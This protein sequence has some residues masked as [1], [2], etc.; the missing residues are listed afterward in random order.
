ML[1]H[2]AA[3][4]ATLALLLA[5]PLVAS[6]AAAD[7]A[8]AAY[9]PQPTGTYRAID[10]WWVSTDVES[11]G[12]VVYR[13]TS[14][15][16]LAPIAE[17]A[18]WRAD[19]YVDF[20]VQL[21]TTYYYALGARHPGG[22][23]PRSTVTSAAPEDKGILVETDRWRETEDYS[24]PDRDIA[25]L[26][27][28]GSPTRLTFGAGDHAMPVSSRD[29]TLVAYASDEGNAAADY[30]VWVLPYG[31]GQPRR[32]T[33]DPGSSDTD[34]AISPDGRTVA[35]TRT[36]AG[37]PPSVWTVPLAGGT[38]AP[39]PNTAKCA[40]PAWS[41]TGR[42]LLAS[43]SNGRNLLATNLAGTFQYPH[44][45]DGGGSAFHPPDWA[46]DGRWISFVRTKG[47]SSWIEASYPNGGGRR[48]PLTPANQFVRTQRWL[49]DGAR[50]MFGADALNGYSYPPVGTTDIHAR[51][52]GSQV[53]NAGV[54][55]APEPVGAAPP[56]VPLRPMTSMAVGVAEVGP[57]SVTLTWE[58]P[59]D[60]GPTW[61][62]VRRGAAGAPA[63][64]T[65]EDGVA[66]YSG[67]ASTGKAP[68]LAN[69]STYSFAVFA[70]DMNGSLMAR[71]ERTARPVAA[72]TLG[73]NGSVLAVLSGGGPKFAASWGPALPTGMTY[74]VQVG[75][76]AKSGSTWGEPAYKAFYAGKARSAVVPAKAGE[77][78]HLRVRVRDGAKTT[79]W[80]APA[81]APVPYD[82]RAMTAGG[83]WSARSGGGR[84][85]GTARAAS[86]AGASLTLAADGSQYA[87]IADRCP[88]CG[89]VKIYVDG[90]LKATVDTYAR[91]AAVRQVV[92]S[93][94][95]ASIGAH[96]IK[97]VVVGT[98]K[99][100]EVRVD[101]VAVT[102]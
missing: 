57:G 72:P 55:S 71:Q 3:A 99:R 100:P 27:P 41:P 44:T 90:V 29:G 83:T 88:S 85:A 32:L 61:S 81:V 59:W 5:V 63:P 53:Y 4:A 12:Y 79:A 78:Y 96:K 43:F 2:K 58:R 20:D 48:G 70:L 19:G 14:P 35:F 82:D 28:N 45:G 65:P 94:R 39:V 49:P 30:D 62:V 6:S 42:M 11:T 69:G 98:A 15:D 77:T 68:G 18:G 51:S 87:L 76:R 50:I 80:S 22:E 93:T 25:V 56:A 66:V 26:A 24:V 60:E 16:E 8:P 73:P 34:P 54:V 21:G 36:P 95:F 91:T 92:W 17:V 52:G 38:P 74:E 47:E 86:K 7:E 97:V 13:G 9:P 40:Q 102:R 46:Q 101:G 10:L 23:G 89:A 31:S 1:R 67:P 64:L 84:F 75:T 33:Q 37:K